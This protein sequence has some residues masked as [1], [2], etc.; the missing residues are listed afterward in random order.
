MFFSLQIYS[1]VLNT[2]VS[3]ILIAKWRKRHA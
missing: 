1:E 2:D 3:K